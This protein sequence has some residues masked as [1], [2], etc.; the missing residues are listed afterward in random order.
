MKPESEKRFK[1]L[2]NRF[3]HKGKRFYYG[4][5]NNFII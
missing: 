3:D 4:N 5:Y 2:S 1:L